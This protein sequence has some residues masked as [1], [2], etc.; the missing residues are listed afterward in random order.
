[1][2]KCF[3]K[4]LF[5]RAVAVLCIAAAALHP[6]LAAENI[7]PNYYG[8][9]ITYGDYL[10]YGKTSILTPLPPGEFRIRRDSAHAA[11]AGILGGLFSSQ[12]GAF[13]IAGSIIAGAA[14][15]VKQEKTRQTPIL[16]CRQNQVRDNE[17]GACRLPQTNAE[18]QTLNP[19]E[20]YNENAADN[21]AT[22]TEEPPAACKAN[23]VRSRAAGIC[24]LPQNSPE[25]QILNPGEVYDPPAADN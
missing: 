3:L 23:E 17:T 19:D 1:M 14:A 7:A 15:V 16:E 13:I 25:C 2:Q 9:S 18:C 20:V 6:A 8:N 10:K 24:R 22:A 5:R 4:I 21:C 11:E 12:I